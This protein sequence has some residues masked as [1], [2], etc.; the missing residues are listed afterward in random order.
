MPHFN[1]CAPLSG[2]ALLLCASLASAARSE[3]D[4]LVVDGVDA[5]SPALQES[6]SR[7]RD[8][9]A[10]SLLDWLADGSLLVSTPGAAGM[11][12]ARIAAPLAAPE[13][14]GGEAGGVS[15]ADAHPFD[16][17]RFA[18]R[19]VDRQGHASLHVQGP[20]GAR[21]PLAE[22]PTR[23]AAPLWAHD[24]QRLAYA[25]ARADAGFD[26]L[27]AEPGA[28]AGAQIVVGDGGRWQVLDW[29]RDDRSLLLRREL[30]AGEE[31][32]AVV[33]VASGLLTPVDAPTGRNPARAR[34]PAAR[35]TPDGRAVLYLRDDGE[36]GFVRLKLAELDGSAP[37][38]LTPPMPHDVEHFDVSA[39]GRYLA[40]AWSEAGY[41][42]LALVD[43]RAHAPL[44]VPAG[45]PAGVIGRLRFDRRGAQLALEVSTATTPPEID[46]IDVATAALTRWAQAPAAGLALQPARRLRFRTWDRNGGR[47]RELAAF[48]YSPAGPGPHP[49]LVLL[50]EGPGG[51]FRPG[52]DAWLQFAVNELGIAVVAPNLRGSGGSGRAFAALADGVLRDDATRDVGSLLV[53]IGAQPLLDATRVALMGGG[54]GGRQALAA[55]AA[56]GDRFRGAV[57]IDPPADLQ[58]LGSAGA[59]L[60]PA[61]LAQLE[62]TPAIGRL[63]DAER[64]LWHMRANRREA[65][66]LAIDGKHC[67]PDCRAA[68]G[69]AHAAIGGYL[70]GVLGTRAAPVLSATPVP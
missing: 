65:A 38:P 13:S 12:A 56:Y 1:L 24:G 49:V 62:G 33:D 11:Q 14:V 23:A 46:V 3:R 57:A 60:R 16:A 55:L 26:V 45:L 19:S 63:G 70:Q 30:E 5:A 51:E 10:L 29:S 6:W 18:L 22:A 47:P 64:L 8:S 42:R 4:G 54:E 41:S 50:H 69:A 66:F 43:Q 53:W 27:I 59:L 40:Y 31:R 52:Y 37:R 20:D 34:V 36:D 17:H 28:V 9:G 7:Y 2:A 32:L 58:S 68:Q 48:L 39:D 61:L 15:D 67:A 44:P 25:R 35:F 21:Q